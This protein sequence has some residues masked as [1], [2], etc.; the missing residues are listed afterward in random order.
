MNPT[1]A[2]WIS[3]GWCVYVDIQTILGASAAGIA[4]CSSQ[5][6][7]NKRMDAEYPYYNL[8][9][10]DPWMQKFGYLVEST[11]L[12]PVVSFTRVLLS[13]SGARKRKSPI[14]GSAYG[15]PR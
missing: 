9:P 6:S 3:S 10:V 5:W 12:Q 8:R 1:H 15:M 4:L 7:K 14:G 2:V 13:G 11:T